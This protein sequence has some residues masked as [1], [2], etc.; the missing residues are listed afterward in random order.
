MQRYRESV[1]ISTDTTPSEVVKKLGRP[2]MPANGRSR[3]PAYRRHARVSVRVALQDC[4]G[5][6]GDGG[7]VEGLHEVEGAVQIGSVVV[8]VA[9]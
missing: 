6:L 2:R 8:A 9:C 7:P 3:D 5:S 1:E 4:S